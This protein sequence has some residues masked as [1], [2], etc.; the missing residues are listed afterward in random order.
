MDRLRA[1]SAHWLG[2][3]EE[4]LNALLPHPDVHPRV[5]HEAMRYAVLGGGKR[6]RPL[7]AVAAA[8]AAGGDEAAAARALDAGCAIE[9]IHAYSL[10]HDDLPSMDNDVLRR[11]RLTCH[12]AFGE[13]IALL[14]GD[15]LQA[16]AFGVLARALPERA[17]EAVAALAAAS[18]SEG[19]AGGQALDLEAEGHPSDADLLNRIVDWKTAALIAAACRLGGFAAGADAAVLEALSRYGSA[20][21]KM[22]Q[23][24][25]DILDVTGTAKQI[26]KTP[27]KD[28]QAGKLT[29]VAVH[30]L[31][32]A[33]A[34]VHR[35]GADAKEAI[36]PFGKEAL[37]LRLMADAL[38]DRRS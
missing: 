33:D 37:Y 3:A 1:F 13:A 4:R 20:L 16:L 2:R 15:A 38:M 32:G 23:A 12:K 17:A 35:L 29:F 22:Y 14:A 31:E 10:V 36:L 21:G 28:K 27:G 18:G 9:L 24:K 6:S 19:M 11:G 34:I 25:D 26:G 5:L 30:G 8:V 7:I